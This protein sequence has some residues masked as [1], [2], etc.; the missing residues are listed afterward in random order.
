MKKIYKHLV[1]LTVIFVTMLIMGIIYSVQNTAKADHIPTFA[2]K[3]RQVPVFCGDTA[4]VFQTA[5][6]TFGEQ[7]IAGA[8]IN[9]GG[10]P[11]TKVIGVL[12]FTYNPDLHTG[13]LMI[14][15]PDT[16]ET[17]ILGY[18]RDWEFYGILAEG[19]VSKH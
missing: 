11:D 4:Y 17:C 1:A 9:E 10:Q 6:E 14:T 3:E 2:L 5:F 19:N 8:K 16:G 18:G 12:S 7:L 15:I 13:S